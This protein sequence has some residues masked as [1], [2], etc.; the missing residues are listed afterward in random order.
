MNLKSIL[1]QILRTPYQSASAI[2]IMTITFF[3]M[4]L[5]LLIGIIAQGTLTYFESKPQVLA[6]YPNDTPENEIIQVKQELERTGI[7]REVTYISSKEAVDILKQSVQEDDIATDTEFINEDVLPPAL[8]I[9]ARNISDLRQLKTIVEEK[10]GVRVVFLEDVVNKLASWLEGIRSAGLIILAL[11]ALESIL[12]V[13]TIIGLRISQRKEEIEILNLLGATRSF[14]VRPFHIEG[15]LYGF[16]GALIGVAIMLGIFT[17]VLPQAQQFFSGEE[18][19]ALSAQNTLAIL[20]LEATQE[21]ADQLSGIPLFPL[22][23]DFVVLIG[24]ITILFGSLLGWLGSLIATSR[25]R[26]EPV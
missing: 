6:F 1:Q 9:R 17:L 20:P 5:F 23:P 16:V 12:V 7:T 10:E 15:V 18:V 14:I 8:E 26:A 13:W 25:Y 24:G 22:T 3:V 4:S 11:L 19:T 2:L 21:W